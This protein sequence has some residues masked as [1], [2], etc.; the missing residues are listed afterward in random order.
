L[1]ILA[2]PLAQ[3]IMHQIMGPKNV[4]TVLS[5]LDALEGLIN[6]QF[7]VRVF[8]PKIVEADTIQTIAPTIVKVAIHHAS[9]ARR[10]LDVHHAKPI[11]S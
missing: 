5:V 1:T 8:L 6:I 2:R 9:P 4:T 10:S 3:Q 11:L 7:P